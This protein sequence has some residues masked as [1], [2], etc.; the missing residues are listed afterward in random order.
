MSQNL[1][2]ESSTF[3]VTLTDLSSDV[4]LLAL[5]PDG[6]PCRWVEAV[7][8]LNLTRFGQDIGGGQAA[9]VAADYGNPQRIVQATAIIAI[10]T[11]AT[12]CTVY[13]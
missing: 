1:K 3:W 10:G 9:E 12:S 4:D 13:W 2:L 8:D 5:H 7:G 11:T 6:Q